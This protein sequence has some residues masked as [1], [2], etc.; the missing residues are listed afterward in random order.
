MKGIC[1]ECGCVC[2]LDEMFSSFGCPGCRATRVAQAFRPVDSMRT[3]QAL[4]AN[5][6]QF[7][8]ST[9]CLIEEPYTSEDR[10]YGIPLGEA[11]QLY[12]LK[13][14]FRK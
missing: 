14:L 2:V 7:N 12:Y 3:A 10:E 6:Q 11:A 9:E 5:L 13:R 4:R 1:K 8:C